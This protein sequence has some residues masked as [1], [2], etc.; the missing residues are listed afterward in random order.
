VSE[1]PGDRRRDLVTK[2]RLCAEAAVPFYWTLDPEAR[3]LTVYRWTDSGYLVA[4]TGAGDEVVRPPPFEAVEVKVA[5]LL[6]DEE[7]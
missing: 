3:S 6:A 5:D 4:L 7:E 2:V 1:S